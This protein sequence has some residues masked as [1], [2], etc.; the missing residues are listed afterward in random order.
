MCQAFICIFQETGSLSSATS[1]IYSLNCYQSPAQ[2]YSLFLH[3]HISQSLTLESAFYFKR[4]LCKI[5]N[6]GWEISV[7]FWAPLSTTM[8]TSALHS[9]SPSFPVPKVR[10]IVLRILLVLTEKNE[11]YW[12]CLEKCYSQ[13]IKSGHLFSIKK[14]LFLLLYCTI[15]L[16][17]ETLALVYYFLIFSKI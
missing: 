9:S 13:V 2:S 10:W 7:P 16:K 6:P 12:D 4:D 15:S 3:L 14:V 11:Y 17:R 8:S 1:Q 5:S